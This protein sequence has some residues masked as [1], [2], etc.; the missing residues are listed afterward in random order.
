MSDDLDIDSIGDQAPRETSIPLPHPDERPKYRSKRMRRLIFW[1]KFFGFV[2]ILFAVLGLIGAI[3]AFFYAKPRY[4]LAYSFDLAELEKV[5]VASR[6]F[7][8]NGQELGRI[9]VQNRRP[10]DLDEISGNFINALLAAED[11]RFYEHQ[12][13]DIYGVMRALYYAIRSKELNQ[14]ASTITQQ[15]AR[16]T[17]DLKDRTISRKVTEMIL[18]HRIEKEL[19]SKTKILELYLNRIYFGSGYYGIASASEGYFGKDPA[20]LSVVEGAT[21]AATIPNP[22]HRSPRS[23]PETS[24]RWRD[25]ILNRMRA[26]GMID[27]DTRDRAQKAAINTIPKGNITG[28]S[29]YVYEKVRQEVI[30]LLGYEAVSKGGFVIQTTID[31][32]IQ[33]AAESSLKKQLSEIEKHPDFDHPTL[34]EY[35][36][37]KAAFRESA[38]PDQRFP[39]PDYLQ[40]AILMLDNR[41]GAIIASV[42]GR[43]FS[44]SMFDRTSQGRR[45]TGTAFKPFVYAAAFEA[46]SFPGTLV[47]DTPLDARK[48]MIGGTTGILG[49]WGPESSENVYEN[50]ITARKALAK[51]KNSATVRM[52]QK[53]GTSAVVRLATAA[54][55]KFEGDLQKF[56]ATFLGRNPSSPDELALAYTIF[57]NSGRRAEKTFIISSVKDSAGNLIYTP[58]IKMVEQPAIDNY[59]ANQI[60]SVL[61][62]TFEYG[63]GQKARSRYGLGDFSVAGKSG[64]E[65]N[66][67]DNWFVGYTTEVTCAAWTG[68]D[69]TK[70]IYSSSTEG[71]FSSDTIL[72][73]WVDAMNAAAKVFTP[74]EFIPPADALE[75]EICLISGERGTDRCYVME[76]QADGL[77]TQVP[78]TY[79]EYLRPGTDLG[80]TCSVHGGRAKKRPS[81]TQPQRTNDGLIRPQI[82]V[83]ANAAPVL[84]IAPT[85]IG[86]EDPYNSVAPVIRARVAIVAEEVPAENR[87]EGPVD[88]NG[89]PIARPLML[90]TEEETLPETR[91]ELPI[92]RAIEFE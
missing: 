90:D 78:S 69:Q 17:F 66:F 74:R 37:K 64:T 63:T 11:S 80:E 57:P 5:E 9:F 91:V 65:Y 25:H 16:Q 45:P 75:V 51:S 6:I 62:D 21:L 86:N 12:G 58:Q 53:V 23:F 7:D 3:G 54:G 81:L 88:N 83:A 60:S 30:R 8:R 77:T 92:P 20:H 52:G 29:A 10:V 71:A 82:Y 2:L 40:G 87:A 67:T 19:N 18:A 76:E 68:F 22:Y 72:P 55:M 4:D 79:T 44:D 43:D 28:K 56:N 42:G 35:K 84:P 39:A 41:T 61:T 48:V 13:V 46:G 14:G 27:T 49:E 34:A 1:S 85:I 47:D 73:V 32:K 33:A 50:R 26:E 24:K 38:S 15:L 70:T 36:A 89:I 31:G 59:T